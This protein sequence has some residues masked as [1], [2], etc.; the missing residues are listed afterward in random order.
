M[1]CGIHEGEKTTR[2]ALSESL[3]RT[4]RCSI[5]AALRQSLLSWTADARCARPGDFRYGQPLRHADRH[6]PAPLL[7]WPLATCSAHPHARSDPTDSSAR[8][9]LGTEQPRCRDACLLELAALISYSGT[10]RT[11]CV[12]VGPLLKRNWLS[13]AGYA[14]FFSS[15]TTRNLIV[16]RTRIDESSCHRSTVRTH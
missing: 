10:W 6:T 16:P 1:Y 4:R 2:F 5:S 13:T 3:S 7:R 12:L 8:I 14:T 9:E 15:P 11:P